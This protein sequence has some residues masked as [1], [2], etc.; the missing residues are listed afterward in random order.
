MSFCAVAGIFPFTG[1]KG[2]SQNHEKQPQIIIPPPSNYALG[3]V[4]F[5]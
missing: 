1:T 4:A 5:S 3:Q 2:L